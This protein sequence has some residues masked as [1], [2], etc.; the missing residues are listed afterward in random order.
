MGVLRRKMGVLS[1]KMTA[2]GEITNKIGGKKGGFL[3]WA[4]VFV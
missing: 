2:G 1:R 4:S 3:V